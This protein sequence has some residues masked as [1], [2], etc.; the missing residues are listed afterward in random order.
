VVRL[1]QG[2]GF[3]GRAFASLHALIRSLRD[4]PLFHRWNS[5]RC[6]SRPPLLA[7]SPSST[8]VINGTVLAGPINKHEET[9][10]WG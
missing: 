5:A 8:S 6:C 2:W 1:L 4:L 10:Q 3:M 9:A 7:R